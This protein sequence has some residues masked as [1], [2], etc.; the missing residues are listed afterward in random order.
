MKPLVRPASARTSQKT[1]VLNFAASEKKAIQD[2]QWW[3]FG[4]A[5]K[6]G[7][8][9]VI[10]GPDVSDRRTLQEGWVMVRMPGREE[11]S[12]QAERYCREMA[13]HYKIYGILVLPW[14]CGL[15]GSPHATL[16]GRGT[17]EGCLGQQQSAGPARAG[18]GFGIGWDV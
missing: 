12:R 3:V 4:E 11:A 6:E 16:S 2:G 17:G 15:T 5:E 18:S 7:L 10:D 9:V 8:W 1:H 14:A 13:N